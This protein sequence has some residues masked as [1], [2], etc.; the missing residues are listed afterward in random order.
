MRNLAAGLLFAAFVTF[1]PGPFAQAAPQTAT[2]FYLGY[3]DAWMKAKTIDPLLPYLTRQG[4]AEIQSTPKEQRQM[5]FEMM[6]TM[7]NMTDVKVVSETRD[8]EGYRLEMTATSPDKQPMKG[9]AEIVIEDGAM[10]LRKES[11]TS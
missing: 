5:M 6:K 2:Q 7:G 3:R 1:A 9:T 10:K 8:G 11:W 4:Q